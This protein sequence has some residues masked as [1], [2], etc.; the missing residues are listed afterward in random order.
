MTFIIT[1][2]SWAAV[3]LPVFRSHDQSLRC[4]RCSVWCHASIPATSI[5]S[6]AGPPQKTLECPVPTAG[7]WPYSNSSSLHLVD[8]I[9]QGN[10]LPGPS[11]TMPSLSQPCSKLL[12]ITFDLC[13]PGLGLFLSSN[14]APPMSG[15]Q[16]HAA[17]GPLVI[18]LVT[19]LLFSLHVR[20]HRKGTSNALA[21]LI[22][23]T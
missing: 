12:S 16:P 9:L 22:S 3:Y 8:Q 11:L 21:A 2:A 10:G 1:A 7:L 14:C 20:L 4:V 15:Q 23:H 13:S 5:L 18:L 19:S 17:R 6:S